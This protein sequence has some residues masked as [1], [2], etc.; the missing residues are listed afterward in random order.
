MSVSTKKQTQW[1]RLYRRDSGATSGSECISSLGL[2]LPDQPEQACFSRK[3]SRCTTSE[4]KIFSVWF[5]LLQLSFTKN[6]AVLG[7]VMVRT[8][9]HVNAR[10]PTLTLLRC[11]VHI[12]RFA[13]L[14]SGQST[15]LCLAIT[16]RGDGMRS[17]CRRASSSTVQTVSRFSA[18]NDDQLFSQRQGQ[19]A[20]RQFPLTGECRGTSK[21]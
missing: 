8:R 5:R 7:C 1:E 3:L 14:P 19:P 10:T 15:A 13:A 4:Q 12:S 20:G 16:C 9:A 17:R 6:V 21:L 2:W 11:T 18:A